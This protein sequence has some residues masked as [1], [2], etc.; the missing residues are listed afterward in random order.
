MSFLSTSCNYFLFYLFFLVPE[1]RMFFLKEY[2][3]ICPRPGGMAQ[4]ARVIFSPPAPAGGDG[5][6]G[7]IFP[8]TLGDPHTISP[9]VA[10]PRSTRSPG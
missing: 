6:G 4:S 1:L 9:K 10:E 3:A 5:G 2:S 7:V 8:N